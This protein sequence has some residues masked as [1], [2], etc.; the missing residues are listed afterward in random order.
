MGFSAGGHLAAMALENYE[1]KEF[2]LSTDDI[3]KISAKPNNG[4]LCYPVITMT[5]PYAHKGSRT[6]FLGKENETDEALQKR[7][8]A[9]LNVTNDT[10]PCFIWHCKSDTSVPYQ[11]SQLFVDKMKELNIDCDY[12]LY[13]RGMHG[14]GMAEGHK[15]VE[16]WFGDCVEW[17]R[18]YGY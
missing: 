14:L 11:N 6:N 18:G 8:S 13:N 16:E 17:L 3:D 1:D 5:N 7:F 4:I 10:S 2:N 15:E 9:E 12:H